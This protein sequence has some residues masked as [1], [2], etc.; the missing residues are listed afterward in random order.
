[1]VTGSVETAANQ[2]SDVYEG[3]FGPFTLTAADRR[4]VLVYRAGL[5]V[6]ALG[7]AAGVVWTLLGGDLHVVSWLYSLF[8]LA[9]GVSLATIH[10]YLAPLHRALQI[11]WAIGGLA[12]LWVAH[13][14]DTPFAQTVYDQPLTILGVGFTFAALTGIFFKEGFCF[15]RLETKILTPLVPL[16]LLGHLT[17]MLPLAWEKG[18]LVTWAVC[19]AVFALRK[20]IQP[21]PPDIG[22]K[23]VFDYLKQQRTA[24]RA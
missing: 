6:A 23:S 13:R 17:G 11:F 18:L 9:L 20:A 10:I 24:V 15:G 4:S 19:F 21:I 16:L 2:V 7:F 8:W 3:Q 14:F 22:D 5:G 12:S 1:M